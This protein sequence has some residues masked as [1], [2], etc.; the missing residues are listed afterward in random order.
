MGLFSFS[1]EEIA[2][3]AVEAAETAWA[4]GDT[5]FAHQLQMGVGSKNDD[6]RL[7]NLTLNGIAS[8]GWKLHSAAPYINTI[9]PNLEMVLVTFTRPT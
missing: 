2:A 1:D 9:G 4:A 7:M 3:K 6:N 5:L 8:V